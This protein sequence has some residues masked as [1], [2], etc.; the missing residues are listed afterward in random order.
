[1]IRKPSKKVQ[2]RL[3]KVVNLKSKNNF[4]GEENIILTTFKIGRA[5]KKSVNIGPNIVMKRGLKIYFVNN[6]LALI[7][8]S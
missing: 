8:M 1:M 4:L 7:V 5:V 2:K 3:E 6:G